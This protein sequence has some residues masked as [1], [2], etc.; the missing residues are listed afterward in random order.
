MRLPDECETCGAPDRTWVRRKI[1]NYLHWELAEPWE[2]R[3]QVWNAA[4]FNKLAEDGNCP[5]CRM[6]AKRPELFARVSR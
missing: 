3:N 1:G 4:R 5:T 6:A 2:V